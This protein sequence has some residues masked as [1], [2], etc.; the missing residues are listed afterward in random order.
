MNIRVGSAPDSWGVWFGNDPKQT[1]WSRFLDEVAEAGYEWIELGPYG[2]L[3]SDL[4]TL[5]A[6]LD[7]RGLK[8]SGTF[9]MANLEEP[10]AWPE[11]ERQALGSC[12]LLAA[13]N[14]RFLVLI[15]D[16]YSDLTTGK[17]L[18]PVRLDGASW[19]R[20][21]GT[22]HRVADIAQNEFGLKLVFH[23]HAETHVEYEDQIEAFL[24]QTD[25]GRVSLCLDTGHHAYRGGDPVEFM[26]KHHRRIPYLHLKSVDQDVQKKVEAERIP[27]ATAVS[28][29]MFC[30]PSKGVV[31]FMALRDVLSEIDYDGWATV[32]QDMYPAP[33]DKPL[34]IARRTRAYLQEIGMLNGRRYSEERGE[35]NMRYKGYMGLRDLP[36]NKKLGT[37]QNNDINNILCN[38][39]G[40]DMTPDEYRTAVCHLLEGKPTVLAQNVGL[41]DPVIYRSTV[42]TRWDT[43]LVEV[44]LLT[45]PGENP[46]AVR[47]GAAVQADAMVKL[48]R[49]GTDPLMLTVEVCHKHETLC[50]ASYRMNAEDWYSNTWR[51]SNFGR[52]HPD[53]L[54]P[55]TGALDPAIPGVYEQRMKMFTEVVEQY[56]ID[57]IEFDFRRWTRMISNPR[58]NYPILT[59]MVR[60]TRKMLDETAQRKGTDRL[61]L[62]VRVGPSLADPPGTEYP[63][64]QARVDISCRDLGLDVQ[65]WLEEDLVD[66]VC[67]SLFWPYLPGLPKTAEFVALARNKNTGIYPTV[68]PL[69]A[70][71]EEAISIPDMPQAEVKKLMRRHRDEICQAAL[72]CYA[73]GADGIST[74]NWFGHA[75]YSP[76]VQRSGAAQTTYRSSLPYMK[77][78]LFVHRF[79]SSTEA[80]QEC[81]KREP[82]EN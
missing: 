53:W 69:P 3:P 75:L 74:F 65:S 47:E 13:L 78:E 26:R 44:S 67:P 2:Y 41:P 80:L 77:T 50:I 66:Y 33:F 6:E 43:Y 57:G 36:G 64:G 34:P 11:L 63:G 28:M 29:E 38:S 25:P 61:L 18:S 22:T 60:E 37:I 42:A 14:A 81:L 1:P 54:I 73:D 71:G 52:A 24:E 58:E 8:V 45:W 7:R 72:Q 39:S 49:S 51:L 32:E 40:K 31:D 48:V 10:A 23:P 55:N 27:F 68:F 4:P 9:A 5:R 56:D 17:M 59:N 12:E 30:E 20:L 16:T 35:A 46:E 76:R 62:G 21:I 19:K 79:L 82:E 15:D 70:W